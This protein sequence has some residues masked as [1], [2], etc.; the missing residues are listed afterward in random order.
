MTPLTLAPKPRLRGWLHLVMTGLV[1]VSG[2]LLV[3]LASGML[4]RAGSAVWMAGALVLFGVSATYHLGNWRPEVKAWL[5]RLDHAN[6]FVFIAA[7]YTPLA[8]VLLPDPVPLL[9]L[10][11][12]AA[13]L[14][15]GVRI[16][17]VD[18]PR[19]L[20]VIAYLALGW[21]GVG[22]L[23]QFWVYG[24]PIIVALIGIGG[25]IYSLG[26]I[27]YARKWPDPWPTWFGYH[28]IFHA[29]TVIAAW[30]HFAAIVLAV[31]R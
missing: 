18:A 16:F 14:G 8:L 21:G 29:A 1:V 10:I 12:S 20:D 24:G 17:W 6:I 19:W 27:V 23:G 2:T 13:L 15:V 7:T 22:W 26:A 30:C 5:R 3:V 31:F 28:E 25:L 9:V 11:W 4:A